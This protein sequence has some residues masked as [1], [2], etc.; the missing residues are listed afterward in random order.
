MEKIVAL[1]FDRFLVPG[2]TKEEF[3][4]MIFENAVKDLDVAKISKLIYNGLY[5]KHYLNEFNKYAN[6]GNM[7][8]AEISIINAYDTYDKIIKGIPESLLHEF[9]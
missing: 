2:N 5:T 9:S 6:A 7:P 1:D 4:G 3:A 8:D